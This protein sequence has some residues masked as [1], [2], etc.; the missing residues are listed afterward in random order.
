MGCLV[1]KTDTGVE[2][3]LHVFDTKADAAHYV[4]RPRRYTFERHEPWSFTPGYD[5]YKGAVEGERASVRQ[6]PHGLWRAA[7]WIEGNAKVT[8]ASPVGGKPAWFGHARVNDEWQAVRNHSGN[9]ISYASADAA[10]AGARYT[11]MEARNRE[12]IA[13][14]TQK[15]RRA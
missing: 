9:I 4:T 8:E 11:V 14:A 12:V 15:V 10:L 3:E 13:A 1:E 2:I 6:G 5:F 7:F